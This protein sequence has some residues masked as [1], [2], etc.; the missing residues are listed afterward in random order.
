MK[1]LSDTCG[2]KNKIHIARQNSFFLPN[3]RAAYEK[4]NRQYTIQHNT[5]YK[6]GFL[7]YAG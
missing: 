1:K 7:L 6:K 2:E 3:T 4:I 5:V